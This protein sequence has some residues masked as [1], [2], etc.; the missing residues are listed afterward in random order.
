MKKGLF[1]I[2]ILCVW[3][4]AAFAADTIKI[5]LLAPITGSYASE[6]QGMKQVLELLTADV[7]AKGGIQGKKV[8]LVTED[9]GS[10]PRTAAL[11]ATAYFAG[12]GCRDRHLRLVGDRAD[13]GHL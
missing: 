11:A 1:L 7:N 12:R 8:T 13:A 2:A 5:G 6:G 3:T 9:D 4:Y 10:D